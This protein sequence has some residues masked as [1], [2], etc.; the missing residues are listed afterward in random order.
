MTDRMTLFFTEKGLNE[1]AAAYFSG[2][3]VFV[4]ILLAAMLAYYAAKNLVLKMLKTVLSKTKWDGTLLKHKVFERLTLIVPALVVYAAAP[5][6]SYGQ[7]WLRRIAFCL[8]IFGLL[9]TLDKFLDAADAIYRKSESSKIRP[10]KGYFQVM[11][12]SAYVIGAIVIISVLMDRSPL[13]LLG[14]I[15]AA[16]AV[17]LLVFQNTILGF[18]ASIQLTEN[19][20][21]RPGDW[22]EM[23][24]HNADG[25]VTEITLHTVKVQNWDKT[26]TTIPTYSMVTESFK[27]WRSMEE[28]GGRR[29]KRS[30]NIDMTS[31][32]FC[33]DEM[34]ERYKKIQYIQEYLA[35]KTDDI[36]QYNQTLNADPSSL[37]NGRHLTN[38]GTF[39][40]YLN[41]YLKNHPCVH[42]G[43]AQIVRQ[44]DPTEH[45]LPIEVYVFSN[46]TAWN[47]YEAIQADIFDH[48]LAIIP[49]FDLRIF[50]SPAG[51]DLGNA[52]IP[53]V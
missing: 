21:V 53:K 42:H 43:M 12:L 30:V 36:Q 14:G 40:A 2:V 24:G 37:V 41:A 46:T 27:N 5:L 51:H 44:L 39:R 8:I 15:G 4:L 28:A 47:D 48:I 9:Q 38:L 10:L 50:Q 26:V 49:E 35:A 13:I 32:R 22:I 11:K 6:L 52:H 17:L 19:D 34:L 16:S 45:G 18:V 25:A 1:T 3:I 7:E 33:T 29:I 31:V 20:M 23:P